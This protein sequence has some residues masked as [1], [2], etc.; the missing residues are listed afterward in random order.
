MPDTSLADT[1]SAD[2]LPLDDQAFA[3]PQPVKPA[4]VVLISEGNLFLETALKLLPYL[5]LG[6]KT[7][8]AGRCQRWAGDL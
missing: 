2:Y 1:S 7:R 4:K 3:I 6:V 8:A 5:E